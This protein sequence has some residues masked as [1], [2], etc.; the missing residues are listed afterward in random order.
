MAIVPETSTT[1]LRD[2]ACG[3]DNPRWG[4]FVARYRPCLEAFMADRFPSVDADD[5]IQETFVSVAKVLPNYRYVPD[6]KG[7]FH[8]F[9]TG[10]LRH[11]ALTAL[12]VKARREELLAHYA[13]CP[14]DHDSPAEKSIRN[15]REAVYEIALQQLLA[16]PD[17]SDRSKQIL[18]RTT[19][20]GEKP[21]DVARSFFMTRPAVDQTKKRMVDKLRMIVQGL[22]SA[23]V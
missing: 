15:W 7:C 12:R 5:V 1:L 17:I 18:V 13:D 10:I 3:A 19:V 8:C 23:D 2:L 4:E 22:E 16:D 9:L 20:R 21:E 6:E 14:S 11:K